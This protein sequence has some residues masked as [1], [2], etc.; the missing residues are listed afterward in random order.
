M[1]MP[2]YT[3]EVMLE[4][5]LLYSIKLLDPIATRRDF[6]FVYLHANTPTERQ[7]EM[8][9][10]RK[11]YRIWNRKYTAQMSNMFL[12]HPTFWF[13][14]ALG[15]M[16]PFMEDA[17]VDKV[18]NHT[19]IHTHTLSLCLPLSPSLAQHTRATRPVM[20]LMLVLTLCLS[21]WLVLSSYD[22]LIGLPSCS[23]SSTTSN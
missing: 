9:W 17:F 6:V 3:D 5:I 21:V 12:V 22:T 20:I 8:A 1:N 4:R 10:M 14:V 11:L 16:K 7:P 13:K 2:L 18:S 15:I 23:N 19:H